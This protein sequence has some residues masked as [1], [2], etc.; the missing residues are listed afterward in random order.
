MA[1]GL[2]GRHAGGRRRSP[3][4][5][6]VTVRQT[7]GTIVGT[8][9]VVLFGPAKTIVAEAEQSAIAIGERPSS[10]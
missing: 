5:A 3:V 9:D 4:V 1:H 10:S 2:R 7:N 6:T 8:V